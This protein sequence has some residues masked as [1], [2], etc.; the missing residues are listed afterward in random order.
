MKLNLLTLVGLAAVI[1]ARQIPDKERRAMQL[2]DQAMKTHS[3]NAINIDSTKRAINLLDSAIRLYPSPNFYLFKYQ[4]YKF[5]NDQRAALRVCDT[6]LMVDK[7]NYIATLDKGRTLEVLGKF[8]SSYRFYRI[9]LAMLD[10]SNSFKAAAI[11][12]DHERI[13][14]TALLKDTSDFKKLVDA[15]REKYRDSKDELF[16]SYSEEFDHFRRENYLN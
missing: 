4:I 14:I 1:C 2:A 10:Q 13:V 7:S 3:H 12:K 15:F 6:V 9:A 16:K 5:T 11:V 8:D